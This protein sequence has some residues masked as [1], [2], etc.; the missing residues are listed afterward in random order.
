[1]LDVVSNGSDPPLVLTSLYFVLWSLVCRW[2]MA[3][4]SIIFS[5]LCYRSICWVYLYI[6]WYWS[7]YFL[8]YNLFITFFLIY[9]AVFDGGVVA[10]CLPGC[11]IA[12]PFDTAMT[13]GLSCVC[14]SESLIKVLTNL[15]MQ[16]STNVQ[17]QGHA[18]QSFSDQLVLLPMTLPFF[19]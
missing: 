12:F 15:I 5:F 10:L 13:V 16:R 6:G 4:P 14:I 1:M 17:L 3:S 7:V 9:N 8:V 2:Y 19:F 11:D 18:W